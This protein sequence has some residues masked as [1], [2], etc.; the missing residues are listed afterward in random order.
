MDSR[1]APLSAISELSD[2]PPSATSPADKIRPLT[3]IAGIARRLRQGGKT[4]V[5]AHGTFDLLHV[6]HVRHLEAARAQG[7]VLIVTITADRFVNKGPG[8]PVFSEMLRAEMLASIH[9]VDWV[10]ISES[11]DAVAAIS[12]IEP[13]LYVKG[14]DYLDPEADVT[15]KIALERAAVE[16][17]GGRV[18]FTEELVFSSS[19][20]INRHFSA[21]GPHARRFLDRLRREIGLTE[22]ARLIERVRDYR[23][24][25]VGD[26]IVDEYQYVLPTGRALKESIPAGR[27]QSSETFAGGVFSTANHIGSF[28]KS[29]DVISCL[30]AADSHEELIRR[31]L[32]PNV[33]LHALRRESAPTTLKRR[34]VD[35]STMR[36]LFEVHVI[37]DRPLSATLERE[38]DGLVRELAPQ[39]DTVIVS[40]FGHGLIGPRAIEAIASASP[41]LA[42]NAQT[43]NANLGYN[44]ITRY[45]RADYVC[46]N[47]HEAR[48][49]VGDATSDIAQ[50]ARR[51]LKQHLNCRKLI[52]TDGE[53]GCIVCE[54]DG[55]VKAIPGIG[56]RVVDSM[57]AGDAFFA[58]TA[59][60][61]AAGGPLEAIGFIGN[62]AG[63]L[64][65]GVAGHR[66]AVEKAALLKAVTALLK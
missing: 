35:P 59:P 43:N 62:V 38:L 58:V 53:R 26:A 50:V 40:D 15:C 9:H 32:R 34:F 24:V 1:L 10:G 37:D 8:R 11:T 16:A 60:L 14:Q 5:Q 19:E 31:S 45:P 6:G 66:G 48:L 13:A 27:L 28:C 56:G 47:T 21:L 51:L 42:V 7:D 23:V 22:L 61:A 18:H 52:V 41:F 20:L 64:K 25:L 46:L 65:L 63:A 29:V 4:I 12:L 57:G 17:H 2:W 3:E 44:L 49:A 54:R 36:K 39:S 30:G 55:S 33:Q